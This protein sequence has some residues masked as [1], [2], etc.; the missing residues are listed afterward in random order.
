MR[1]IAGEAKG[2]RL[3]STRGGGVRPSMAK[4]KEAMFSSIGGAVVGAHVLD[5]FAGSGALGIEALSRGAALVVF[6]EHDAKAAKIVEDNLAQTHLADRA[7]VIRDEIERFCSRP[8]DR[9]FALVLIDPP[10]A[11]GLPSGVLAN[12]LEGGWLTEDALIV[13]EV[14]SRGTPERMPAGFAL[15]SSRKY[16]DTTLLYIAAETDG[17]E[18]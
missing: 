16:G 13:C 9:R 5:A 15:R 4:V 3:R 11:Q 18:A 1:V 7:V 10:Y 12:L 14:P 17:S 2:R 8:A 6:V